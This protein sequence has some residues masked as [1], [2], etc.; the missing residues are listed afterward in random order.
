MRLERIHLT[1]VLWAWAFLL[2]TGT[3]WSQATRGV[4][5]GRATDPSAA[6]VH[7]AK[8]VLLNKTPASLPRPLPILATIRLRTLSPGS[9]KSVSLP[10]V[11]RPAWCAMS[12][13][14][15]T[16]PCVWT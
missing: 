13:C 5:V 14:L 12:T 9:T 10:R 3:L 6:V 16:R 1:T 8:V 4:I 2:L 7:G 11:S 15:L